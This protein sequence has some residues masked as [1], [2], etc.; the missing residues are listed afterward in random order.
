MPILE[1]YTKQPADVQDYDIS[2]VDWLAALGATGASVVVTAD[3]GVTQPT[4]ATLSAGV[5]KVWIAG[6]TDG[7]SYKVTC[8]LT[9]T[10]AQPRVKQAEI[11]IKVKES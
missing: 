2:Y 3:A 7:G 4:P 9:T 6:G 5:V 11:V 1:K 10:G 8:T